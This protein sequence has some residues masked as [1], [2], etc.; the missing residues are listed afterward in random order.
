MKL[1]N[2]I[3]FGGIT[4]SA[5]GVGLAIKSFLPQRFATDPWYEAK[6]PAAP[7]DTSTFPQIEVTFLRC[8]SV[9]I[10]EFVAVRG[11]FSL[12]PRVISYS[13]VLVRH[14]K[15]TFLYD[16]GLCSDISAFVAGKPLLFRRTLGNFQFEQ[17]LSSHLKSI[18]IQS[19]ESNLDFALLSHLHWDHVS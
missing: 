8:G 18:G 1:R 9:T 4:L 19:K 14:P 13:A 15:A 6:E 2:L 5:L 10:P 17:S 3:T 11:T 16:T 7:L 12:A